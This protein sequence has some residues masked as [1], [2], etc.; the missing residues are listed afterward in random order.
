MTE[1]GTVDR[2]RL[3]HNI[4][5]FEG[6]DSRDLDALLQITTTKR[7]QA[8]EVLLRK[9]DEERQLYGVM[10]GRLRALGEGEDGKQIVLSLINP[11]EILGEISLLDSGR[12]SATVEAIEPCELLTLHRRDLYPFLE[13]HP[14]V[15][16]NLA[17]VLGGHL[18]K[19]T[20]LLEDTLFLTLPSR[21]AK[22]L[23]A[24]AQAYGK[25]TSDGVRIELRLSQSELGELVGV[26]RESI[27]K[28]MR[29]WVGQELIRFEGGFITIVNSEGLRSLARLLVPR[30]EL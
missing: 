25:E 2:R 15:A 3:L 16:M 11:G 19:L 13:K 10:S 8:K 30:S 21:L 20:E 6:L 1:R 26:S 17:A 12:R 24:L 4:S 7:L 29:A 9:G 23:V 5:I 28:Q 18:R 22:K 14:R 27:N